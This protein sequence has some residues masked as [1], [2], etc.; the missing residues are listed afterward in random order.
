VQVK[1]NPIHLARLPGLASGFGLFSLARE[2]LEL[3]AWRLLGP[4]GRAETVQSVGGQTVI[5]V[6][7]FLMTD[8]STRHIR[9]YLKACGYQVEVT[10]LWIN[11]GP[12]RAAIRKIE[13]KILSASRSA[14]GPI[15]LLGHSFGGS[16]VRLLALQHAALIQSAVTSC[17]PIRFP[18]ATCL[19]PFVWLLQPFFGIDYL[20]VAESELAQNPAVPV[21]ALYALKDGILDWRSCLQTEDASHENIGVE[22]SHMTMGS[23][24]IAQKAVASALRKWSAPQFTPVEPL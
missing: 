16:I 24:P 6:P 22:G 8:F 23:N 11:I 21:T 4:P 15:H 10:G 12:T 13:S 3:A 1:S 17:A 19:A 5:V 14:S 20:R 9:T 18:V 2:L 7:G